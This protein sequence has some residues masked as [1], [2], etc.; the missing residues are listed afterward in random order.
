[1]PHTTYAS[2]SSQQ[3]LHPFA[4]AF[5]GCEQVFAD[6]SRSVVLF[7]LRPFGAALH[8]LAIMNS[9]HVTDPV[10]FNL[11]QTFSEQMSY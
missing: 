8:H 9:V 5:P 10:T 4:T 2:K 1:M 3:P 11:V 7:E 6:A